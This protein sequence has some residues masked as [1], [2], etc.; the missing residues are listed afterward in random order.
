MNTRNCVGIGANSLM[1]S[2]WSS[3]RAQDAN[4]RAHALGQSATD[5]EPEQRDLHLFGR[6]EPFRVSRDQRGLRSRV[7]FLWPVRRRWPVLRLCVEETAAW[8]AIADSPGLPPHIRAAS[9]VRVAGPPTTLLFPHKVARR[10][11]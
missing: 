2:G 3:G 6:R 4:C 8:L 9:T 11:T 7:A 5:V 1:R 10:A